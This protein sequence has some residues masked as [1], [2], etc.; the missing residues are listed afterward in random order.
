MDPEEF[1]SYLSGRVVPPGSW[2]ASLL[3]CES[4]QAMT[5]DVKH[6]KEMRQRQEQQA[7]KYLNKAIKHRPT[8]STYQSLY[9]VQ[10]K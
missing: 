1:D 8:R 2:Q 3:M 4:L 5:Q 7:I 9:K 10:E 6:L